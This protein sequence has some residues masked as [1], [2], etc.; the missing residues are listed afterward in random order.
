MLQLLRKPSCYI[1]RI[2]CRRICTLSLSLQAP[3]S[4]SFWI[5]DLTIK[6]SCDGSTAHWKYSELA[7]R[8]FGHLKVCVVDRSTMDRHMGAIIDP[9]IMYS[10]GFYVSKRRKHPFCLM[11]GL[12]KLWCK[13]VNRDGKFWTVCRSRILLGRYCQVWNFWLGV[14]FSRTVV[15]AVATFMYIIL[16]DCSHVYLLNRD[17]HRNKKFPSV[18]KT[19]GIEN[20]WKPSQLFSYKLLNIYP[21]SNGLRNKW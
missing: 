16:V 15:N 14:C 11:F 3:S 13:I 7:R 18:L 5:W 12:L 20:V 10:N 8:Y 2:A 9:E 6:K 1:G 17:F 19:I 4:S 21:R